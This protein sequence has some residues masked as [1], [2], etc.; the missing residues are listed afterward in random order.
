MSL[1]ERILAYADRQ[2]PLYRQLALDIHARP[3]T[4]NHEVF[5]CGLLSDQLRAEGFA[6]TVD[7]AGHPTGFTGVYKSGKPGPVLAFLAEYDAL[8]GLG[9]GCGH[10]LFGPTSVLAGAALKQVI[11]ETGGEIRVYGTPGEEGGENGSAKG[12]FVRE[13]Y[14]RDVDAALCVHPGSDHHELTHP[15]IACAPIR[16]EFKGKAAHASSAPQEGVN[17]LDALVLV[18]NAIGLLRQQLPR[19]VRIH[20]IV[21]RGGDAPNIIPD[22]TEGRFYVRA[23]TVPRMMEVLEKLKKIVEGAALQTGCTGL[24]EPT[25]RNLIHNVVPTPSFDEVYLK[26]LLSLGEKYENIIV[27]LGSSDVGNVSQVIPTIQ[28]MIRISD[29]PVAGHTIEKRE[30]CKSETGLSSIA[31]GAKVLALTALDL[32]QSPALLQKIK[33]DHAEAVAN[34]DSNL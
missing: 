12:S 1:R 22:Y 3:E 32:I 33:Q 7:V 29:T 21:T 28:P 9:H 6:V 18:F 25:Q 23:A 4:S 26:N 27:P 17:A 11:D 16:I 30:A 2:Y 5:A 15:E 8:P 24:L 20:G 19:D 31:L 13:G 10:N 34:Q 14:F